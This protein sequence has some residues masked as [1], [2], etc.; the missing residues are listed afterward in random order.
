MAC[1]IQKK[2]SFSTAKY[3]PILINYENRI[4]IDSL[5]GH[6]EYA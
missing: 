2:G 3:L 5:E 6:S 1:K 4:L